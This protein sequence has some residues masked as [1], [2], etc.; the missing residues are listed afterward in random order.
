MVT[1]RYALQNDATVNALGNPTGFH[2]TGGQAC[3]LDKADVPL[4][5]TDTLLAGKGFDADRRVLRPLAEAGK[6]A[7]IPLKAN[8]KAQLN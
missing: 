5:E 8:R 7:V 1:R 2:L 4:L 3:D 6:T